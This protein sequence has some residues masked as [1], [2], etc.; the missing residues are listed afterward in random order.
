MKQRLLVLLFFLF[1][2]GQSKA[3]SDHF[4]FFDSQFIAVKG[5]QI[6]YRA[7]TPSSLPKGKV[8]L[9]HG[10]CGSTFSWRKNGEELQ[11]AGYE[12]IMVDL[13]PFGYSDKHLRVN[14][15]P[16]FQADLLW[17]FIDKIQPQ[18]KSWSL[19]GH[20]MGAAVAA[21]MS[22]RR[23]EKVENLIWL[24]G[25]IFPVGKGLGSGGKWLLGAG[26]IQDFI[27]ITGRLLFLRKKRMKKILTTAYNEEPDDEAIM[28]YLMPL[29]EPKSSKGIVDLLAYSQATFDYNL[30]QIPV[31]VLVIWGEKD[32]WLL[33]SFHS[34]FSS[35]LSL[36]EKHCILNAGHCPMETHAKDVNEILLNW[37]GRD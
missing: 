32:P 37:L 6:H 10:F 30:Y 2:V 27:G 29:L 21:A 1:I 34:S 4:P 28:G 18:S 36:S 20:S 26:L 31:P 9:I 22:C 5:L 11:K 3:Q 12:V 33:D 8:L 23:P 17:E 25:G 16:S 15:S 35:L 24:D 14:H 13:P 19:V 7:L